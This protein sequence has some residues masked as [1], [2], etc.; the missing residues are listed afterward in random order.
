[1]PVDDVMEELSKADKYRNEQF[2]LAIRSKPRGSRSLEA[3]E[4]KCARKALK[5]AIDGFEDKDTGAWRS[6]PTLEACYLDHKLF[7]EQMHEQGEGLNE[8][9]RLDRI[10]LQPTN[11]I[12]LQKRGRDKYKHRAKLV[13]NQKGKDTQAKRKHEDYE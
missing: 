6:W 10:A 9:R 1:M 11:K 8:M 13:P 12:Q 4:A 3:I 2:T 5:Q 7:Q